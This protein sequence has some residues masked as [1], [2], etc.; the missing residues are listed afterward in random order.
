MVS[1]SPDGLHPTFL[2]L[3]TDFSPL[4]FLATLEPWMQALFGMAVL[5]LAAIGLLGLVLVPGIGKEV[6]GSMRWICAGP[7]N[8]QVSEIAKLFTL[9][10]LADYLKR[11]GNELQTNHFKTSANT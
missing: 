7:I 8:V 4:A 2:V 1:P 3:L 6:N 9:V 11:H 10:Y 5:L